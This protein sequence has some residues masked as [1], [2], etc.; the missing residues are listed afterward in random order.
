MRSEYSLTR[1]PGNCHSLGR[2]LVSINR[3]SLMMW[4]NRS[5]SPSWVMGLGFTIKNQDVGKII[6]F[7]AAQLAFKLERPGALFGGAVNRLQGVIP[8]SSQN[9]KLAGKPVTVG[10]RLKPLAA[11]REGHAGVKG[12][13]Q[14]PDAFGDF[15]T[16]DLP[17]VLVGADCGTKVA[18]GLEGE[19]GHQG[20]FVVDNSFQCF[21]IHVGGVQDHVEACDGGVASAGGAATVPDHRNAKL[22]CGIADELQFV[23]GPGRNFAPSLPG[24]IGSPLTCILIQSTPILI[25]LWISLT[26][27][28]GVCTIRA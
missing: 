14:G 15:S 3:P 16:E 13:A 20:H 4:R 19:G 7:D 1:Q 8:R 21:I 25:C 17:K 24:R 5:V 9:L 10:V 2:V 6:G 12:R 11:G 27:S 18:V 23:Q 22:V 26:I 28:S